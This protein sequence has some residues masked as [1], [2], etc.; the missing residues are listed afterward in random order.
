MVFTR[1]HFCSFLFCRGDA[2]QCQRR[3]SLDCFPSNKRV[4]ARGRFYGRRSPTIASETAVDPRAPETATNKKTVLR[5]N[6]IIPGEL[7][8]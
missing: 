4:V 8:F 3:S 2:E 7:Q 6:F 5:R 1:F